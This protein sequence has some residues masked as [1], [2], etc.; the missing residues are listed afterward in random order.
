MANCHK[1]HKASP[2]FQPVLDQVYGALLSDSV[3]L[4]NNHSIVYTFNVFKLV[5]DH[6]CMPSCKK[7]SEPHVRELKELS[8][9]T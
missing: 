9:S 4:G 2:L 1:H 7:I 3:M 8:V 6:R 5:L